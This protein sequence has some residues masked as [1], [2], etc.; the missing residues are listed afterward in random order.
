MPMLDSYLFFNGACAEAMNFYQKTIGGQMISMLKYGDGPDPQQCG[1]EAKDR[2]M[3][4]HLLIDGRNLM[5]SDCPPSMPFTGMK[6]MSVT[7]NYDELAAKRLQLLHELVPARSA[8][9]TLCACMS[10][11]IRDHDLL[12]TLR[13]D[14]K[15]IRMIRP[16]M[17][18]ALP[19]LLA[20]GYAWAADTAAGQAAFYRQIAQMDQK[21]TDE[22]APRYGEVRCPTLILWGE[23]DR[24]IPIERGRQLQRAIPGSGFRAIAN[25]GHL[26]QED[27]PEAIVAALRSFLNDGR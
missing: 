4:A 11:F 25:A 8:E 26:V 15:K 3:H 21:Y 17:L 27:A 12:G 13:M 14:P 5:A 19:A 20:P 18:L 7:L 24:W 23:Q 22:V 1:A 2:I 9:A 10:A 16:A 6:G